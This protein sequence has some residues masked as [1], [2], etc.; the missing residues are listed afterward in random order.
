MLEEGRL[1]RRKD[2]DSIF[3]PYSLEPLTEPPPLEENS[4]HC[5]RCRGVVDHTACQRGMLCSRTTH[6]AKQKNYNSYV[7]VHL[8]LAL[9][10]DGMGRDAP[11]HVSISIAKLGKSKGVDNT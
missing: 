11:G 7:L 4:T 10:G 2:C 5:P 9:V 1:D 8:G 6:H 3:Y